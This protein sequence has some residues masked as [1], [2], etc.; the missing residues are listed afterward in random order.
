MRQHIT[1]RESARGRDAN[2][3]HPQSVLSRQ[4]FDHLPP[5]PLPPPHPPLAGGGV[6]LS[7]VF[8]SHSTAPKTI[9][10]ITQTRRG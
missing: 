7:F 3:A 8:L 4:C 10:K 6:L 2:N 9:L 5:T 1:E